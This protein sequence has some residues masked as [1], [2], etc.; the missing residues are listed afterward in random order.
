MKESQNEKK[1]PFMDLQKGDDQKLHRLF[2]SSEQEWDSIKRSRPRTLRGS[3]ADSCSIFKALQLLDD[4]PK[5]LMSSLQK[6][7]RSHPSEGLT[8][9]KVRNNDL[10]ALEILRERRAAVESG[11]LKG[12]RLFEEVEDVTEVEF[13]DGTCSGCWDIGI[14]PPE[15]EVRSIVSFDSDDDDDDA[16]NENEKENENGDGKEFFCP[17]CCQY[18]SNSSSS[19]SSPPVLHSENAE[20][21]PT[22]PIAV[23]RRRRKTSGNAMLFSLVVLLVVGFC[24]IMSRK[25]GGYVGGEVILV[26]T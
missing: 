22:V 3:S 10:A 23:E 21:E 4:S 17:L 14:V 20:E 25:S 26:P 7:R 18:G 11:N 19:S 8:K 2:K 16:E 24:F 9:W 5:S 13:G 12:R 15:S 1:T 6:G